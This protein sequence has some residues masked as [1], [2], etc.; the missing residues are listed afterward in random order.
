MSEG[1]N[2][3]LAVAQIQ[4]CLIKPLIQPAQRERKLIYTRSALKKVKETSKSK[5]TC[6]VGR[7]GVEKQKQKTPKYQ[8]LERE[9]SD[10]ESL[11]YRKGNFA[12]HLGG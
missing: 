7:V 1:R 5:P 9:N 3:Q 10:E 11:V 2:W 8:M 12:C 4:T 6:I